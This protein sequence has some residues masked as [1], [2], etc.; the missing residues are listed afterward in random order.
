MQNFPAK[1][2]VSMSQFQIEKFR[3]SKGIGQL[4]RRPMPLR[5][6]ALKLYELPL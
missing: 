3:G 6:L 1:E 4:H 2:I 5:L